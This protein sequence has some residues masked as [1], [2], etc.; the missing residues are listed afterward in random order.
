MDDWKRAQNLVAQATNGK[1]TPGSGGGAIKGD[2]ITDDFVFEVKQSSKE[3]INL[4]A[5]WFNKLI[6]QS[7]DKDSCLVIFFELRGYPY[8][9][10]HR[11][12]G[13]DEW[14][15]LT[16]SEHELPQIL[17]TSRGVWTLG[18]FEDLTNL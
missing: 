4:Q 13:A 5:N 2:V 3:K 10:K 18:T 16:I 9:L 7:Q 12:S 11:R 15:S 14:K 17:T 6:L 1:V 8:F